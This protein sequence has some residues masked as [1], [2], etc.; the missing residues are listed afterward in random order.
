MAAMIPD[1]WCSGREQVA[2]NCD[3]VRSCSCRYA[4]TRKRNCGATA[5]DRTGWFCQA[6]GARSPAGLQSGAADRSH[7]SWSGG[8]RRACWLRSLGCRLGSLSRSGRRVLRRPPHG[9]HVGSWLARSGACTAYFAFRVS[10]LGRRIPILIGMRASDLPLA[11]RHSRGRLHVTGFIVWGRG[12]WQASGQYVKS[13]RYCA[14]TL[15]C[16]RMFGS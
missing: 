16:W 8:S 12:Q 7:A 1:A 14:S 13:L 2:G 10:E 11:M 5:A 3:D 15:I 9:V 4:P 6:L